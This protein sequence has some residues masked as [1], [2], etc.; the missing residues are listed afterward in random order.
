MRAFVA[1][2]TGLTGRHVVARLVAAGVEAVAH[3]RP[4]SARLGEWEARFGELGAAVDRSPWTPDG[5]AAA[6]AKWAPGLV[7]SLLGTTKARERAGGG[8]YEAVDYGL[9]VMLIDAVAAVGPRDARVVYLSSLG[10]DGGRGAYLDARKRV[11]AHL[12][13]SG[14][15]WTIA[16]PSLIVGDRDERRVGERVAEVVVDSVM[17]VVGALGGR[18]V[19]DRARSISGAE[20]ARGLVRWGLDPAGAGRV[21]DG[22]AL[23]DG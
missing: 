8:D 7:F 2:A 21:V 11:E 13:Q 10:A 14:V 15:A 12:R 16:R 20:L 19:A 5:M 1:G 17:A 22:R 3:V 18:G 9:S 6:M 23:R 4:D